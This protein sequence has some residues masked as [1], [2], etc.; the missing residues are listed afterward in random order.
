MKTLF[1][2]GLLVLGAAMTC[3]AGPSVAP[4]I[5]PSAGAGAIALVAGG[6]MVIRSRRKK[7]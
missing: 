2:L 3:L 1:G 6:L 5:D 4:E 7:I